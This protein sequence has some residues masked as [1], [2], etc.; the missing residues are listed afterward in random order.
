MILACKGLPGQTRDRG[1]SIL[2]RRSGGIAAVD[3]YKGVKKRVT[4]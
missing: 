1:I 3:W 4:A 2:S